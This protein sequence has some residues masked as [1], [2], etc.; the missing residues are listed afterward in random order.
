M[1]LKEPRPED[2]LKSSLEQ[3]SSNFIG[4]FRAGK[5]MFYDFSI[6]TQDGGAVSANKGEI[7]FLSLIFL[8]TSHPLPNLAIFHP[9][10]YK[11]A[12]RNFKKSV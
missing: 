12:E 3:F 2:V 4:Y 10:I 8:P 1:T 7:L 11:S 5:Q 9:W 6:R